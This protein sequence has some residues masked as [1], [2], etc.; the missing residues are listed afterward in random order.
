[1]CDQQVLGERRE[2]APLLTTVLRP[3]SLSFSY[4]HRDFV[5]T[6]DFIIHTGELIPNKNKRRQLP[7]LNQIIVTNETKSMYRRLTYWD[8]N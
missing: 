3:R 1:M 5:H 7:D 4:Q 8:R 6:T 2:R